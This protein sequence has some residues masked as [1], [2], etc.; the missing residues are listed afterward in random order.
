MREVLTKEAGQVETVWDAILP[1][2]LRTLPDDLARLDV[3]LATP[4]ATGAV[5]V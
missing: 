2:L 3:V 4:L 1:E 5:K